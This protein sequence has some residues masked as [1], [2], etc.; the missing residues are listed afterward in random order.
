M[1]DEYNNQKST[2]KGQMKKIRPNVDI[3]ADRSLTDTIR[4]AIRR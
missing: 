1:K 3:R 2:R 4:I